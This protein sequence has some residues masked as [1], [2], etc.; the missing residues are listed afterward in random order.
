M[1]KWQQHSE[2]SLLHL[3][4]SVV[5]SSFTS[6]RISHFRWK[7]DNLPT[8]NQSLWPRGWNI[9][10]ILNL[11]ANSSPVPEMRLILWAG[12]K[13]LLYPDGRRCVTDVDTYP[14]HLSFP[15]SFFLVGDAWMQATASYPDVGPLLD[16]FQ[17]DVLQGSL[18]SLAISRGQKNVCTPSCWCNSF[19]HQLIISFPDFLIKCIFTFQVWCFSSHVFF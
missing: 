4:P 11:L 2:T 18:W 6:L 9:Y 16:R 7:L 19:S 8:Q 1:A 5:A 12:V 13:I 15:L 14:C 17:M 3:I 10:I